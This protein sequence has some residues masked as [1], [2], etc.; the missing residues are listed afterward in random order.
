MD[1]KKAKQIKWKEKKE[2][3]LNDFNEKLDKKMEVF[4]KKWFLEKIINHK[5]TKDILWSKIINDLNKYLQPYFKKICII[6]WR[7]SIIWW[8]LW[9]FSWLSALGILFK[10]NFWIIFFLYTIITLIFSLLAVITWYGIINFKKWAVLLVVV[11]FILSC[12]SFLFILM[13][14]TSLWWAFINVLISFLLT[15]LLIK[16]KELFKN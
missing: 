3:T 16:N 9:I 14:S 13:S 7:I 1:Q 8:F 4:M 15:I 5:I 2:A 12:L 6:M 11:E 10:F